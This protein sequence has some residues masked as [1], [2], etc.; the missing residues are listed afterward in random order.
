[1]ATH[2]GNG[3]IDRVLPAGAAWVLGTA[4]ADDD[5]LTETEVAVFE[6]T[7]ARSRWLRGWGVHDHSDAEASRS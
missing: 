5:G 7:A 3:A 4:L 2:G 6:K 1:M